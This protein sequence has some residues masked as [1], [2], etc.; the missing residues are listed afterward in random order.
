MH[1]QNFEVMSKKKEKEIKAESQL[2]NIEESLT[3]TEQFIVD[4]QN[5]LIIV[6]VALVA[7]VLGYFGWNKYYMEPKTQEAQEQIY[8]AQKYFEAD[9]L[10]K[11]LFGDGNNLGFIDI[12]DDYGMTKP[13]KLANY[14]AGICYL[15]KHDYDKAIEYLKDFS[16]DDEIVSSMAVGAIGDAYLEKGDMDK[17][18]DYYLKASEN[19]VNDFTTPLF[20]FKAGEVCEMQNKLDDALE[21]YKKI[22]REY[23]GSKEGREIEKY[24]GRVTAKMDK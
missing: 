11:A 5:T 8:N 14:Y 24:I 19:T 13:G 7:I 1:S 3:K 6:V 21:L 10:D 20:L 23:L 22:K 2:S 15:K 18:V 12:A 16:A 4:N 9:S 17:A